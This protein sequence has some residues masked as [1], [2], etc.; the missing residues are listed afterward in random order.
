MHHLLFSLNVPSQS[1]V[2]ARFSTVRCLSFVLWL[3]SLFLRQRSEAG[4]LHWRINMVQTPSL[5]SHLE[6][7]SPTSSPNQATWLSAMFCV[8]ALLLLQG[9]PSVQK[10]RCLKPSNS[11]PSFVASKTGLLFSGRYVTRP[12]SST[13]KL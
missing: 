1:C 6:K 3:L 13:G 5:T 10:M 12:L 4:L 8:V 2:L 9:T 11:L 7:I